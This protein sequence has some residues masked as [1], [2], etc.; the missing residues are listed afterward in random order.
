MLHLQNAGCHNI[1][2][3]SPSHVVPQIIQGVLEAARRGLNIPLIYNT[4]GYDA[5][6]TLRL[7]KGIIDIYMPD[8]KYADARIAR[9]Y[10]RIPDYPQVN[11]AAV[12][13][14]HQQVGDL[15][16]NTQ[17]LAVKGL[18]VRHLVL[19]NGLA[20]TADIA[21]FLANQVSKDT[22]INIMAQYYPSY[23]AHHFPEINRRINQQEY[24]QAYRAARAAGLHRFDDPDC[25]PGGMID[26]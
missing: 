16:I 1:N 24:E 19:P 25:L 3:V 20:G 23:R 12:L 4:G 11:Q 17:G 13:E 10:S 26:R 15:I 21:G 7:L 2:F 14:M 6:Q 8:M 5:L 9:K 22:Y 18:L